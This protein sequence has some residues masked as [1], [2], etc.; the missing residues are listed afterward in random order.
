MIFIGLGLAIIGFILLHCHEESSLTC[1]SQSK[2]SVSPGSDLVHLYVQHTV[3]VFARSV[4]AEP[5]LVST[6]HVSSNE[7]LTCN[8]YNVC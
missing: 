2:H 7:I 6:R 1:S 4:K 3:C 5:T 8:I